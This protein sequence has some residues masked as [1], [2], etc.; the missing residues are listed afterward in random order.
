[1]DEIKSLIFAIIQ[2]ITEL[3]PISSVAHGVL[4]PYVFRWNLSPAF[5]QEHFLPYVVM[6]HVGTALALL[7]FFRR[8]WIAIVRSL[9]NVRDKESR[10]LLALIVVATIPAALI[11]VTMEKHL[12]H[13]FS[14]VT[15][16][17]IFLIVNGFFLYFGEK[18]RSRGHKDILELSFGQ[19]FIVGL[20]QSLAL[21]PGFS[22]SGSSMIAGFW[23]GLK[24]ESAARFSM[25]LATPIIVGA[26]VLEIPKLAR[27]G[28]DGLFRISLLG[29]AAAAVIAYLTVWLM[30]KWFKK[31]D[32]EAMRPFAYYCWAIGAIIL[33]TVWL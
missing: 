23:A 1:M 9:F 4:T 21:I 29:G 2:G 8:E 10:R 20:F 24:H 6:L 27:S 22:R 17:S 14:S 31:H 7:V 25:L 3:F 32:I 16:A 28:M 5:L 19:A 30:M 12:R 26:G 18:V 13:L 15:S 11:G 33:L